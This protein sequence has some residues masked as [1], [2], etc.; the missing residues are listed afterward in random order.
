[1]IKLIQVCLSKIKIKESNTTVKIPWSFKKQ[2]KLWS[3]DS[4]PKFEVF[5]CI[6]DAEIQKHHGSNAT[7]VSNCN[8]TDNE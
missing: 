2:R 8:E 5:Y 1:L 7:T 3:Q 6:K 4:R